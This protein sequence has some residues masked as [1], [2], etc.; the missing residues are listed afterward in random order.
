M[1]IFTQEPTLSFTFPP[2]SPLSL[3]VFTVQLVMAASGPSC[4]HYHQSADITL[5]WPHTHTH[6]GWECVPAQVIVCVWNIS[7]AVWCGLTTD[8]SPPAE[9]CVLEMWCVNRRCVF[10]AQPKCL[11]WKH[12]DTQMYHLT[13]GVFASRHIFITIC[14]CVLPSEDMVFSSTDSWRSTSNYRLKSRQCFLYL[15][16]KVWWALENDYKIAKS[17]KPF[18]NFLK[19]FLFILL[20][21]SVFFNRQK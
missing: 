11:P 21:F 12:T 5:I 19:L 16:W 3:L 20:V 1:H 6:T 17:T 14:S 15:L 7:P 18:S 10:T 9:F 8:L 2:L 4:R 13:A